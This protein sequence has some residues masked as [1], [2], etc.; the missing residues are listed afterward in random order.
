MFHFLPILTKKENF[1]KFIQNCDIWQKKTCK[2][3]DKIVVAYLFSTGLKS[4]IKK[5]KKPPHFKRV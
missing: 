5:K 1:Y 3:F 2:F 4:S